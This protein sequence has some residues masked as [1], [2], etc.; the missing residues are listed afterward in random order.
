MKGY[1]SIIRYVHDVI[2]GEFVNVG[3]ALWV[4]DTK[5]FAWDVWDGLT[6]VLNKADRFFGEREGWDK[7][8]MEDMVNHM[9]DRLETEKIQS[10]EQFKKFVEIRCN[11]IQ[12]SDLR[13]IRIKDAGRDLLDL[14]FKI[15]LNYEED[16]SMNIR[17]WVCPR[18][19]AISK[20]AHTGDVKCMACGY[21]G[22][23]NYAHV[24]VDYKTTVLVP[25]TE[26]DGGFISKCSYCN[27]T[28]IEVVLGGPNRICRCK[29][30]KF[31]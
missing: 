11:N 31:G 28:G 4:E 8:R 20:T 1:Y 7:D 27:D 14:Y 12:F 9:N 18:C 30:P 17:T 6:M 25:I 22:L 5:S 2:D 21:D 19:K 29:A 16:K 26:A 13:G 23:I 15:V 24:P 10:L 3:I